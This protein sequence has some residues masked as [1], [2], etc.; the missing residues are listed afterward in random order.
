MVMMMTENKWKIR[1]S[2]V[3]GRLPHNAPDGR[4][5][6]SSSF[7]ESIAIVFSTK[8]WREMD[9]QTDMFLFYS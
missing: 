7:L 6:A 3:E 9:R 8:P 2:Q 1:I 5:R 4:E